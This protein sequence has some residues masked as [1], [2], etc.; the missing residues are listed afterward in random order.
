MEEEQ[1]EVQETV[2]KTGEVEV[3]GRTVLGKRLKELEERQA[4]ILEVLAE[5][6]AKIK[7]CSVQ[8]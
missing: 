5:H 4:L 7:E 6:A 8:R 1:T 2:Q 3:D